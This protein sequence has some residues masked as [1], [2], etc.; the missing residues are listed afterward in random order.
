MQNLMLNLSA[1]VL[2]LMRN[3]VHLIY[4][5]TEETRHN[6]IAKECLTV[7]CLGAIGL[8]SAIYYS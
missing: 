2:G 6:F 7:V 5:T 1:S 8:L 3:L 4:F